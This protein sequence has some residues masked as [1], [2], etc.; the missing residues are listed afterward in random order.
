MA[1]AL[2][3]AAACSSGRS[4]GP[5]SPT[6]TASH[7]GLS[8]ESSSGPVPT[9]TVCVHHPTA[10][11]RDS[12]Y[13]LPG[14]GGRSIAFGASRQ[15]PVDTGGP[16]GTSLF[17]RG[18]AGTVILIGGGPGGQVVYRGS[19]DFDGDGRSDLLIDTVPDY[20]TYIV[21]GTLA[22]GT[23]DPAV[24]GTSVPHPRDEGSPDTG[25]FPAVVGDQNHDGADD[26]SVG[27]SLYS[28]R[29][30]M[31]HHGDTKPVR[32][33]RILSAS[34]AGLL[35]IDPADAP[36]SFVVPEVSDD[37]TASFDRVDVLDRRSDRLVL[38]GITQADRDLF[39]Q[40]YGAASGALVGG[41]Y[42]VD[43]GY[44]TRSGATTW[45]FDLDAPCAAEQGR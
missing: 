40:G 33:F 20:R 12:Y 42:I 3:L 27:T 17:R 18:P 25:A 16:N 28:G 30:V 44:S 37:V 6:T 19:G 9:T 13:G 32:P 15:L 38:D 29:Q 2:V 14:P 35:Q 43:F 26:I 34:Y 31:A 41:H 22:P 11:V 7:S 4:S 39:A 45:R 1:A 21:P 36:P 8:S 24:V 10:R 23:Y 5:E